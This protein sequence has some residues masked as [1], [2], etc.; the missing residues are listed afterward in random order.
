MANH[1]LAFIGGTGAKC[2]E[3]FIHMAAAG[4]V[5]DPGATFHLLTLDVDATNGNR[6]LAIEAI[7]RYQLL[8]A[9]FPATAQFTGSSLF[10]PKIVHYDWHVQLPANSPH[11]AGTNC[12][13]AMRSQNHSDEEALMRLFYSD[14]ELAFDF[15]R[16][17][18]HA[19]P[20]IGAP[21]LQHILDTGV[22]L[23][24]LESFVDALRSEAGVNSRLVI[25]GS[26]FGGTGACGI[27]A[28]TR[29]LRVKTRD[30][31]MSGNLLISAVLLLPYYHFAE[32]GQEDEMGVHARKF[33]NNARGALAFYRDMEGELAYESLYLIGS[34]LDYNMGAY[35]AGMETQKNPP[36]PVE[37][38]SSLAIAH[39][40]AS[41]PNPDPGHTLQ[42]IKC[43]QGTGK[44]DAPQSL[45]IAWESL[46]L[47]IRDR[48]GTMARFIAAYMGY[49]R[50][51]IHKYQGAERGYKPFY[52]ELLKSYVDTEE[53]EHKGLA[54]LEGF[55]ARYWTWLRQSLDYDILTQT[56]FTGRLMASAGYPVRSLHALIADA[57]A[58]RWAQVEDALFDGIRPLPGD[59]DAFSRR[60]AGLF[61]HG[62]YAHCA[63]PGRGENP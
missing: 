26:I 21:V 53:A 40:I 2:A 7:N 24:G 10:G 46:S 37:W 48:M 20:A 28:I 8:R 11:A 63:P 56:C 50:S 49:Y 61:I 18:F 16:E 62:L 13:H 25:V 9:Q 32:P 30:T 14:E 36:T 12:L 52:G 51:Y 47:N 19:I 60:S 59:E 3:S 1:F 4:A 29:Y 22:R 38:E 54:A 55:C 23:G 33:Y 35:R 31:A 58:P 43:G 44:D 5:G 57:P 17:G 27:P 41:D 15:S 42:Y 6:E 45:H 39:C 34:P